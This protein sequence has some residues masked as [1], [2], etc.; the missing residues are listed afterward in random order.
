[1]L[2]FNI[3]MSYIPVLREYVRTMLHLLRKVQ[4]KEFVDYEN[5]YK[6]L[7]KEKHEPSNDTYE[8]FYDRYG[9]T[10]SEIEMSIV[11]VLSSADCTTSCLDWPDLAYLMSRDV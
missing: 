6:S 9:L 8:F 5:N 3:E 1:M 4:K 11:K 10:V 7:C 2:G